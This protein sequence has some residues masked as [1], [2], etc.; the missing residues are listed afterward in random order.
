MRSRKLVITRK[1]NEA[2]LSFLN[3]KEKKVI[4]SFVKE[5]KEKLG[6]EIITIRLFGSKVRGDFKEDSDL[7]IFILVKE[8]TQ[9]IRD[10]LSEIEVEYDIKYNLPIS[11]V[12]YNLVEYRKNKE[13]NSFFFENVEKEGIVL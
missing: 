1:D 5:L 6:D 8:R 9:K 2:T 12:L 4:I 11:T 13:L 3:K 10:I 7:D